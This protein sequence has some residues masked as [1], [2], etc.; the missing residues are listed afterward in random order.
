MQDNFKGVNN[1]G[2][3]GVDPKLQSASIGFGQVVKPVLPAPGVQASAKPFIA[4]DS[5]PVEG[6][7]FPES[8]NNVVAPVKPKVVVIPTIAPSQVNLPSPRTTRPEAV[9][10]PATPAANI[11]AS[12]SSAAEPPLSNALNMSSA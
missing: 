7:S 4:P 10:N 1:P 9:A 2:V 5:K 8:A 3:P 11:T 12:A 6:G